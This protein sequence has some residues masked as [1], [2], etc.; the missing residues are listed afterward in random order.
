LDG[1]SRN[2]YWV[3]YALSHSK[4]PFAA[5]VAA[6]NYDPSYIQSALAD[7]RYE[8]EQVNGAPAFGAG[9]QVWLRRAPGFNIE[10]IHTPLRMI[11]QSA[12]VQFIMAKWETYSRLR[13]LKKPVEMYLMPRA[14]TRPSHTPQ[15]PKQ[16]IAIQEGVLDWFS[17]WLSGRED[18]NPKKIDQY[19]RW[20]AFR[21]LSA[22]A[23]PKL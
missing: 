6:D 8:D 22:V 20:R 18:P 21:A 15:N 13:H 16:I 9:L 5:A 4:F 3:E 17:F 23:D 10:Y 2:G 7:W 19:S 11:G 1:F 12:G 14:D